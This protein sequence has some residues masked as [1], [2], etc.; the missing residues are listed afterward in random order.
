MKYSNFQNHNNLQTNI[1]SKAQL[2]EIKGG[3]TA[4]GN[5]GVQDAQTGEWYQIYPIPGYTNTQAQAKSLVYN[6]TG[7]YSHYC[8]DSCSWN[9][10][11]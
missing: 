10:P 3:V 1:L 4:T 2:K 8:C 6:G 11:A 9:Q 5:C 7:T